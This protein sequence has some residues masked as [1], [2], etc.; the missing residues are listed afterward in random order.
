MWLVKCHNYNYYH[1]SVVFG[2]LMT[3]NCKCLIEIRSKNV[4]KLKSD[5]LSRQR[6]ACLLYPLGLAS[7]HNLNAFLSSN[8]VDLGCSH[9][10]NGYFIDCMDAKRKKTTA[11]IDFRRRIKR[12]ILALPPI[13]LSP[14]SLSFV[15]TTIASSWHVPSQTFPGELKTCDMSCVTHAEGRKLP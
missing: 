5:F 12:G 15:I 7:M 2:S 8:L 3:A 13:R 14:L 10:T 11:E 6:I 4:S 9:V 1:D